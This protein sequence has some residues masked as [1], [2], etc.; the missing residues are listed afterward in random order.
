MLELDRSLLESDFSSPTDMGAAM[1]PD[2]S[3]S[4]YH[5]PI[6]LAEKVNA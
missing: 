3:K 4:I 6:D 1:T 5:G 2:P